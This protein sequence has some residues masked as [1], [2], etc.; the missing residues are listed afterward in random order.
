MRIGRLAG[1][2]ATTAVLL[3]SAVTPAQAG[4]EPRY[5]TPPTPYHNE[6]RFDPECVGLD[7]FVAYDYEGVYSE[8]IVPGTNRQAFLFK[9]DFTFNERWIDRASGEVVLR[10]RGAYVQEETSARKV[11][12]REVPK[13]VIPPEGLIGPVYE[14][15][16]QEVG[17]DKV[18]DG[19]GKLLYF[20]G[21]TVKATSLFDTIGDRLPG[22]TFLSDVVTSVKG[23]HP[24]LDVD[25]CDV[26]AAQLA[27]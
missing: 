4:G 6:G 9:D 24:L 10:I 22:G 5:W 11:P 18:R 8:Q 17:W 14:F 13:D 20:T 27:P 19:D 26:A 7:L 25:I 2:V 16:F 1:L 21:G 15:R 23:P 3:V 12:L